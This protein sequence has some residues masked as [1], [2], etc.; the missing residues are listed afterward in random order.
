MRFG[1]MGS[2]MKQTLHSLSC[3][4]WRIMHRGHCFMVHASKFILKLLSNVE[5]DE[6]DSAVCSS[7]IIH[8][9]RREHFLNKAKITCAAAIQC[10]CIVLGIL[11]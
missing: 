2:V 10:Q 9:D 6:S 8:G 5:H 11:V 7:A 3:E 1:F 4:A